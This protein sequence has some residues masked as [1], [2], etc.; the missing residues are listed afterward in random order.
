[1]R[2]VLTAAFVLSILA[3]AS[4]GQ[5]GRLPQQSQ[6]QGPIK[7][8]AEEA[9]LSVHARSLKGPE[10]SLLPADL[11]VIENGER[12]QVTS[13]TRNPA[14]IVFV[15]DNSIRN[16]AASFK[17]VNLNLN[18]ALDLLGRI[19]PKDPV[20]VLTYGGGIKLISGWKTSDRQTLNE[21][22]KWKFR[23][24]NGSDLHRALL[25]AA[26]K[27]LADAPDP[28]VVILVSDGVGL[29][30]TGL[31]LAQA[32]F[33]KVR[34]TV[35][36]ASQNGAILSR[37]KPQT[38]SKSAWLGTI[39]TPD[40]HKK[41]GKQRE[42]VAE[43]EAAAVRL[44]TL[45]EGSGGEFWNPD[46]PGLFSDLRSQILGDIGSEYV[47]SY[48]TDP[49]QQEEFRKIGVVCTKPSVEV[50]TRNRIYIPHI[51]SAAQK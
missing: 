2:R 37:L 25:Y 3:S 38:N 21:D 20:A 27:L 39:L 11:T 17:D 5:S 36:V 9:F 50:R 42:L 14:S 51:E 46:G 10:I 26:D 40:A 16:E 35:Y 41:L 6:D 45:A 34:A 7:L 48:R 19:P 4:I 24:R 8:H 23:P 33:D 22:I 43:M 47:I 15:L 18:L 30:P 31:E 29:D 13:V 12:H 44:Q 28:R 1:M 32:E 49:G